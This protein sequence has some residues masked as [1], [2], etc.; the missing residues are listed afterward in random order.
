MDESNARDLINRFGRKR[1]TLRRRGLF[2][3]H[4]QR[5]RETYSVRFYELGEE[6]YRGVANGQ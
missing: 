2:H 6:D 1:Q 5:L 3:A 4:L